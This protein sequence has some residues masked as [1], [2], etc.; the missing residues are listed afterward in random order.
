MRAWERA[1]GGRC[2]CCGHLFKRGEPVQV[3]TL[4]GVSHRMLRCRGCVNEGEVPP[5]DLPPLIDKTIAK[6][7]PLTLARFSPAMLPIDWK[8]RAVGREPGEEG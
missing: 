4:I 1:F 2:G 5:A 7:A 6:P 8:G 3:L